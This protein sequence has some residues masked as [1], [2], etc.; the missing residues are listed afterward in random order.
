M[1]IR[2][3]IEDIEESR[4]SSLVGR[5]GRYMVGRL[6]EGHTVLLTQLL[7]GVLQPGMVIKACVW[8]VVTCVSHVG[9]N[10]KCV[11]RLQSRVR[12]NKE[13][14]NKACVEYSN[15]TVEKAG[16]CAKED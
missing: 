15:N 8:C 10:A 1:G 12:Y 13:Y 5:Q 6:R 4:C 9:T 16:V 7:L 11:G 14:K 3:G 2:H